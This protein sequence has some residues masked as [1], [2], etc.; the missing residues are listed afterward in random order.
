MKHE[1]WNMKHGTWNME[2]GIKNIKMMVWFN[3]HVDVTELE[4]TFDSQMNILQW[5]YY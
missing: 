1:K 5:I 3:K 2:N 4:M